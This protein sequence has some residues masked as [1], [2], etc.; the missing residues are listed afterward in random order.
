MSVIDE[1][2][3]AAAAYEQSFAP[4]GRGAAP[5]RKVAV[6]AC[7]DARLDLFALLGLEVGDAHLLR[8]GGGTLTDDMLRSLVISQR[9][10]GTRETMLVH[11]TGCGM[12]TID[13]DDILDALEAETGRRPTWSPQAFTR[14]EDDVA[15]SLERIRSCP[16][17]VSTEA[18]GFV[19]DVVNGELREVLA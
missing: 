19:F 16:W 5:T 17:L 10:L 13:D 12:T 3:T 8:N 11:H 6:L 15:A 2:V 1:M 18:R 7:M 9:L 4:S 14:P